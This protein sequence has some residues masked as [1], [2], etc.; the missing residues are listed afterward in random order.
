MIVTE[1]NNAKYAAARVYNCKCS[2]VGSINI[3]RRQ[4][5]NFASVRR[6]SRSHGNLRNLSG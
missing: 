4:E 3:T 5:S 2:W 1:K 6:M